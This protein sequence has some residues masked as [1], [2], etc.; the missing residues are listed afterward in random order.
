MNP[1]RQLLIIVS[2]S[3]IT[4]LV[5]GAYLL[6]GSSQQPQYSCGAVCV[7]TLWSATLNGG[8][9]GSSITTATSRLTIEIGNPG[10]ATTITSI[11]L[12]GANL[13]SPITEWSM[14]SGTG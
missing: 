6:V 3:L 2:L 7:V 13:S 14:T 4:L 8:A 1:K 5:V 11:R 12:T 9:T 10:S